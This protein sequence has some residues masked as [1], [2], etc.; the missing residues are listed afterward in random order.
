MPKTIY[1]RLRDYYTKVGAV[2]RGEADAGSIFPNSTDVGMSR[3]KVYANFLAQHAPSMC[4]VFFGG[5]LFDEAGAE[6]KQ[7]DIIITTDT[8]PRF[9]FHN[10]DGSGKSFSHV[11]GTL[12]VVSVKS[13]LNGNELIDALQ[14]IAS[15]P[16]TMPLAGRHNPLIQISSYDDWP[17]KVLYASNGIAYETILA[18][19]KEFYEN[20]ATIPITRRPNF[21]HVAGK[22]MIVRADRGHGTYNP[23]T[24]TRQ[25]LVEGEYYAFDRDPDVQGIVR[26]IEGIQ[27]RAVASTHILFNYSETINK[28]AHG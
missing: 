20:N 21:I 9:D 12:G 7:L 16:P 10:Q 26:I 5:F 1:D 18:H 19:I 8:T 24:G 28:I 2:L 11:E 4:R 23:S 6:S 27:Q 3:E 15:I 22:Y 25:S 13:T 17:L 14:N